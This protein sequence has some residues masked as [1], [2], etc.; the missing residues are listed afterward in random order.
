MA[1][2]RAA[3]RRRKLK[4]QRRREKATEKAKIAQGEVISKK[5]KQLRGCLQNPADHQ[6]AKKRLAAARRQA[7]EHR[8]AVLQKEAAA[9]ARSLGPPLFRLPAEL[10]NE[11]YEMVLLQRNPV[12][13]LQV[14]RDLRVPALL[15]VSRQVRHETL[16]IWFEGNG[17]Y[18]TVRDCNAGV[19]VAWERHCRSLGLYEIKA[20]LMM[21]G[22][23]NWANLRRWCKAI[24]LEGVRG[25]C[26]EGCL[27]AC[28][29]ECLATRQSS[30]DDHQTE[31]R[32]TVIISATDIACQFFGKPSSWRN[33]R[34][35]L[36]HLRAAVCAYD[37]DWI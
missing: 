24:C 18:Y 5:V 30:S 28:G 37:G 35:V 27:T 4:S 29:E 34:A 2:T 36:K 19:M 8:A 17:F 14:N 23:P 21:V 10:R 20:E 9:R 16:K 3:K 31:A 25:A 11:I 26:P 6:Q 12:H 15:Q 1:S 32:H 13:S 22:K 33:C 7:E